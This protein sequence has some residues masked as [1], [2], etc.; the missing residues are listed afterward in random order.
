[1]ERMK[2]LDLHGYTLSAGIWV[3]FSMAFIMA[4]GHGNGMRG[5]PLPSQSCLAFSLLPLLQQYSILFTTFKMHTFP[6]HH[7]T[8]RSQILLYVVTSANIMAL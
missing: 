3:S 6:V 4:G 5:V 2:K 7:L 1:M 8:S